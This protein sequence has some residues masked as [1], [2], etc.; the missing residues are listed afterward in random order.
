MLPVHTIHIVTVLPVYTV[1]IVTVQ[2]IHSIQE[3]KNK[4]VQNC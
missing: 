4:K 1:H 3:K 2:P